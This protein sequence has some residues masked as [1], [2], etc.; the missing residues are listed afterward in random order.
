MSVLVIGQSA[1]LASHLKELKGTENWHFIGHQ[2]IEQ[3]WPDDLKTVINFAYEPK[4]KQG[5][6]SDLD[7]RLAEKAQNA[8]AA[9]IMV[10]SRTAYGLPPQPMDLTEDHKTFEQITPYGHAK[11]QI[12]D[13]LLERFENVT[14]LRA[15]NIFGFEYDPNNPRNTFFGMMLKSLKE[16]GGIRFSMSA[17][18]RRD[19]LPLEVFSQWIV[20]IA[21]D[22][23]PGLFNIGS[24]TGTSVEDIARWVIKGYGTGKLHD[25]GGNI[26]DSFVLDMS[27]TRAAYHLPAVTM[28]V[29]RDYCLKSGLKLRDD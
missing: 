5:E 7:R 25:T 13:D 16:K 15:S 1:F 10:S 18:T 17:Q 24:G 27:K 21:N 23:K 3:A 6:F 20:A 26:V 9:Y 11:K 29:I 4:I 14:I 2:D 28:E 19:F 12:E 8:E 22:P